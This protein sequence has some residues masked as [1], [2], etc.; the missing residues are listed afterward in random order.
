MAS[1][2]AFVDDVV[3]GELPPV[4]AKTGAPA[5][6][7]ARVTAGVGGLSGWA[8]LLVFL[9]PLG[10][11]VLVVLA[12]SGSGRETVEGWVPMSEAAYEGVRARR[13]I[14]IVG[15]AVTALSLLA[16]VVAGASSVSPLPAL[17][18][19]AAGVLAI[20]VGAVLADR[21][22]VGVS[23][24]GSRRWVTLD[25]VHPAFAAAVDEHQRRYRPPSLS[26]R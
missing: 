22:D 1:A 14:I 24:D 7:R 4:C 3:L 21:A 25:R 2:R 15:L 6:L 26:H 16:L 11:I 12:L 20:T 13:R 17:A 5:D 18:L 9:G 10:W 8:F 19:L 23:L